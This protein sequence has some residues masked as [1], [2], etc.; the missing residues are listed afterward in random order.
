[1][2]GFDGSEDPVGVR[3][4]AN[5]MHMLSDFDVSNGLERFHIDD[6]NVI[7]QTVGN[8]EPRRASSNA[9]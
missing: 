7:A 9:Y 8:V 1:M 4:R 5:A 2:V 3:R 6:S